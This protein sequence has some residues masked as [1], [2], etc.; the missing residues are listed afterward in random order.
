MDN[1]SI[2]DIIRRME[3]LQVNDISLKKI[4]KTIFYDLIRGAGKL[5]TTLSAY[6]VTG[7]EAI[8][9]E[10][11]KSSYTD[12]RWLA[13][14]LATVYHETAR[15]MNAIEEFGKG[16]GHD[17]GKKLK[18]SRKPY[19]T[20][21]ELYYGR[22]LVQLTWY[23]NYDLMGKLLKI[24]LLNKPELALDLEISVKILFEGM[25][26]GASLR[27]DFTGV[28]LEQFFTSTKEDWVNARKI[29]N[30]LDKAEM[31]ANYAKQFYNALKLSKN[32]K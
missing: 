32:E 15:T 17:Y 16:R 5:F 10:W 9:N 26:K 21:D 29:I 6:Q 8:L 30:G 2:S 24:D 19:G 25:L 22:G 18:M 11:E 28:S 3:D 4:D 1:N 23:E 20:P 31:I 27:G 14:M 7:I 12:L 13:Y